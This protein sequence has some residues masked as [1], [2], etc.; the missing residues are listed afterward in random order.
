[1]PRVRIY[2]PQKSAVV[3]L[4]RVYVASPRHTRQLRAVALSPEATSIWCCSVHAGAV[5]ASCERRAG[6]T[7]TSCSFKKQSD[8]YRRTSHGSPCSRFVG[9]PGVGKHTLIKSKHCDTKQTAGLKS[10]TLYRRSCSHVKK[11][12]LPEV[13]VRVFRN[14][15][16]T[17]SLYSKQLPRTYNPEFCL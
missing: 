17:R 14:K 8:T 13:Y 7:R 2:M 4:T 5:V 1:M 10:A 16:A 6:L 12:P 9:H 3:A 11:L 15:N